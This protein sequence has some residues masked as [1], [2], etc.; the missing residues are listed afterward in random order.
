MKN[1]VMIDG[2]MGEGGGQVFR[3][4][5]A[6][7]LITG[8]P[9]RITNIRA[10]R[11]QGGLL[12]QHL[13]ALNA[14]AEVGQAKVSGAEIGSSEVAFEPGR[15][16]P[17]EFRFSVGTAGSAT[18]VLQTI[19]PALMTAS[20]PSH[21]VL[22]GGTHNPYAPPYD[23]LEKAFLPVLRKMGPEVSCHLERP[24]FYPAGGGRFTVTVDPVSDLARLNL[25]ERGEIKSCRCCA[26]VALLGKHIGDREIK[27]VCEEMDW[28]REC[29][30]IVSHRQSRGPGNILTI[31]IESEGV[32]EVFTGFGMR[33]VTAERVA[34]GA[35]EEAK[36]YLKAD[37]PVGVHLADQILLPMALAGGGSFRTLAPSRHTLT[38]IQVI[39]SFLNVA[40]SPRCIAD[41]VWEVTVMSKEDTSR[42]IEK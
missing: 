31:A 41:D 36:R 10:G 5:L 34:L 33:G 3:T 42:G 15:V 8:K 24:G 32:T 39:E 16:K 7:S 11:K 4:S 20:A 40:I 21:L 35:V 22:E 27:V 9:F 14:A 1:F 26:V 19:L 23:F 37:V 17:G 12:R 2:A 28:G 25:V 13:T 18:L 30:S 6:L 38:N 29:A